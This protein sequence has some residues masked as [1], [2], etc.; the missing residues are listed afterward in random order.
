MGKK[1]NLKNVLYFLLAD[2][3]EVCGLEKDSSEEFYIDGIIQLLSETNGNDENCVFK[4]YGC[5][6]LCEFNNECDSEELALNC[7]RDS[8]PVM[9]KWLEINEGSDE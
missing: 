6:K 3:T 5:H 2:S 9:K 1:I 8:L 7:G 4:K